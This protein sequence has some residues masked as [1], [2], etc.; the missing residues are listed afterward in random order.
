[1]LV[2]FRVK[3]FMS[4]KE[5]T[6]LDLRASSDKRHAHTFN[7]GING[8]HLLN[9]TAIYG[10]NATGKTTIVLALK[11]MQE[12]IR[13]GFITRGIN[14][15]VEPFLL[16]K[17]T[18]RESSEFEVN[19]V[20]ENTHYRYGFSA[21][22]EKIIKEWL[23]AYPNGEE[24]GKQICFIRHADS[25]FESTYQ[26]EKWQE[27]REFAGDNVLWLSVGA[28][29]KTSY[30]KPSLRSVFD[31]FDK[32]LKIIVDE[33]RLEHLGLSF[34]RFG[35]FS[36]DIS[37]NNT[38]EMCKNERDKAL[39]LTYL[40]DVD[41][42]IKNLEVIQEERRVHTRRSA[43]PSLR[44]RDKLKF[45]HSD[46]HKEGFDLQQESAGTQRFL[47]LL[48]PFIVALRKGHTLIVDELNEKLHS[49]LVYF[50]WKMFQHERL[51]KKHAQLVVT[52]HDT[53]L[54]SFEDDLERF[55]DCIWFC[56]KM[57]NGATRLFPLS[58][59]ETDS[60]EDIEEAYLSGRFGG[61]P[62]IRDIDL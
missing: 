41:F 29:F 4:I 12:I 17:T 37:N 20:I 62:F 9:T 2:N 39:I 54:L 24:K 46:E 59:Y 15:R 3:N 56:R 40:E 50:L 48:A 35:R 25:S 19:L 52:T 57:D 33:S 51:N 58:G 55:I 36:N 22:R 18:K 38:I 45:F 53:S 61:V 26:E 5:S 13:E 11:V 47:E 23:Y 28:V 30:L 49:R 21:T 42:S 27:I 31:W 1:M 43:I 60:I 7:S 16:D 34:S 32:N 44:T 6:L 8:M 10:A 14:L